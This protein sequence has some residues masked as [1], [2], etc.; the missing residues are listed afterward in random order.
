MQI[1]GINTV[2]QVED[3]EEGDLR[4]SVV[5]TSVEKTTDVAT[6]T[7]SHRAASPS[8]VA[9]LQRPATAASV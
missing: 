3:A 6:M 4:A 8:M 1:V 7:Q 5:R 9:A 2:L